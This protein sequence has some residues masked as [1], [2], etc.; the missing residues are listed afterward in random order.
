M[1]RVL[2]FQTVQPAFTNCCENGIEGDRRRTAPIGITVVWFGLLRCGVVEQ[3]DGVN[4]RN[5]CP[6]RLVG[7][8]DAHDSPPPFVIV[9]ASL[10]LDLN[11]SQ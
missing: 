4:L 6:R 1:S 11:V 9:S 10:M 8:D 3:L 2:E 7:V 5:D